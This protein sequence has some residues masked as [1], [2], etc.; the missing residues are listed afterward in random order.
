MTPRR[1]TARSMPS[2]LEAK[3]Y[4]L[5]TGRVAD[6]RDHEEAGERFSCLAAAF[7]DAELVK[8]CMSKDTHSI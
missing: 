6:C 1:S 8:T 5:D 7:D 3:V 4:E 2:R